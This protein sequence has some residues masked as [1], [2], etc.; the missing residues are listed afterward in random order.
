MPDES[1]FRIVQAEALFRDALIY[2]AEGWLGT[3]CVIRLK[4]ASIHGR[5]LMWLECNAFKS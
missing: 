3:A 5:R 4:E 1:R 2:T